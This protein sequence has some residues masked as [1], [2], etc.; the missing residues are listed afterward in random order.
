MD[1]RVLGNSARL[2]HRLLGRLEAGKVQD[3]FQDDEFA[4]ALPLISA[5]AE[6]LAPPKLRVR[7]FGMGVHHPCEFVQKR[8]E[9]RELPALLSRISEDLQELAETAQGRIAGKLCQKRYA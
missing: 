3:R 8:T 1:F 4:V 7:A 9:P 5:R 2:G 6:K